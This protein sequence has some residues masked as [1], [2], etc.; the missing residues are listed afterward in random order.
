[1]SMSPDDCP[2]GKELKP[3]GSCVS[4][5]VGTYRKQ[6]VDTVCSQCAADM[7]T[8]GE[9]AKGADAC[10]QGKYVLR[11]EHLLNKITYSL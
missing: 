1:M 4:C 5:D 9:G 11:Y 7:T 3:D 6:G 2:S 10:S 8:P